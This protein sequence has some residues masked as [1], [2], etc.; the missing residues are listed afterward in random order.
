MNSRN[1]H[2]IILIQA[3]VINILNYFIFFSRINIESNKSAKMNNDSFE[4][5]NNSNDPK[6]K[7]KWKTILG[8]EGSMK[9]PYMLAK[10]F[11][12]ENKTPNLE[13]RPLPKEGD[14]YQS[15]SHVS[16]TE[17]LNKILFYYNIKVT[18]DEFMKLLNLPKYNIKT[19]NK[20]GIIKKIKELVGSPNA[21]F[22]IPGI[23]VFTHIK[24]GKKYV[25]SSSQLAIRLI[26]Y[27]KK[28]NKP[29][30]LI[31]PLLY[32]EGIKNFSLEIIPIYDKWN[33]RAELVLEQY[34]LL[35]PSFSLNV[36]KVV[37]NPS[38]S[39]SK[40]LYMYNRDKTILYYYSLQQKDFIKELKIH[41]E[42]FKKHLNKGTYYLGKYSFSRELIKTANISDISLTELVL[43]LEKERIKY[44]KNKPVNA[45]SRTILLTS[46]NNPKEVKVFYGY[47]PCI[48][49]LKYEKGVGATKETLSKYIE[50]GLPYHNYYCKL[51]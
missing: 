40:P 49:F 20:K 42:T 14:E 43:K 31:R 17:I 2:T 32:K 37:N 11:I 47:R 12:K 35:D 18:N 5:N 24:S 6:K 21:K 16:R 9:Y 33:Y 41:F 7:N 46:I 27:I 10:E 39:N 15:G 13:I 8:R 48:R 38:G 30:G 50:S 23:Y 3:Q 44:N 28:K 29:L 51:V 26:N 4:N 45:N 25:G 22:Q 1:L 36:V 19:N 34:Y